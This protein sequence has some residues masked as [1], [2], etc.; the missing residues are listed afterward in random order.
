MYWSESITFNYESITFNDM[1]VFL[2]CDRPMLYF[3]SWAYDD[4][5]TENRTLTIKLC[6]V[7]VTFS[8]RALNKIERI[9]WKQKS[10]FTGTKILL[11]RNDW[12][13]KN[14]SKPFITSLSAV[15]RR[16]EH[17]SVSSRSGYHSDRINV[18]PN[19]T[20]STSTREDENSLGEDQNFCRARRC[21][22]IWTCDPEKDQPQVPSR[23]QVPTG[24]LKSSIQNLQYLQFS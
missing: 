13:A 10:S 11:N 22:Y 21:S 3:Q 1:R 15:F 19:A 20:K 2:R 8:R 9:S 14:R 17:L 4:S 7:E 18:Q 23:T 6:P 16:R 5:R 24:I 12:G